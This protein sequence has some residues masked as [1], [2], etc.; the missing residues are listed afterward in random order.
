MLRCNNLFSRGHLGNGSDAERDVNVILSLALQRDEKS[1][2]W[3]LRKFFD[4]AFSKMS[5]ISRNLLEKFPPPSQRDVGN[6]MNFVGSLSYRSL[7]GFDLN[8]NPFISILNWGKDYY[9]R[10]WII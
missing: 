7:R 8:V 6:E 5:G 2:T 9:G 10:K 4:I 1:T 3:K